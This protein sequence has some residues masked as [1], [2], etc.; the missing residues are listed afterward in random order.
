MGKVP[1]CCLQEKGRSVG[2]G[3][4]IL[5]K[6]LQRGL[7]LK[8][9]GFEQGLRD[10]L[11]VLVAA[12]PLAQARRAQV[13][14]GGELGFAHHL[15]K[16]GDSRGHRPDWLRLAPIWISASLGHKK[17]AFPLRGMNYPLVQM[18]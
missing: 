2:S 4:S 12:C 18:P 17:I 16:F 8:A 11:R 14:V 10:V 1:Y 3:P 13:L 9:P 15:L 7:D 5:T 6:G